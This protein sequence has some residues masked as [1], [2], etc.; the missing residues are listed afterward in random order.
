MENY[1][2]SEQMMSEE[3][4][5][6]ARGVSVET[7]MENAGKGVAAEVNEHYGPIKGKNV[8]AVLG[9]GNNGG[10]GS[11]AARYLSAMGA[12]V[13]AILLATPDGIR[14]GEARKNWD[15]LGSTNT[16]RFSAMDTASLDMYKDDIKNADIVIAAILG[17][18]IRGNVREPEAYAIRLVNAS[19]GVKVAVDV[20]SGLD[21]DTGEV[22]DPTVRADLTVTL[23]R[24]KTGM[25][26]RDP[27]TGRIVIVPIGM[28]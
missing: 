12:N 26:G 19:K 4:K 10:D 1:I 8:V 24:P 28:D 15:R 23:H 2:T 20:P 16:K 25:K 9:K 3:R 14:T 22:K 6:I 17:T 21:P 7:L 11:V 5:A 18:G 27:I 13:E